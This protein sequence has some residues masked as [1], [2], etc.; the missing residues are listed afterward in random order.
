MAITKIKLSRGV[1]FAK[2]QTALNAVRKPVYCAM[3]Q[4]EYLIIS[5]KQ[6]C[7]IWKPATFYAWLVIQAYPTSVFPAI[8]VFSLRIKPV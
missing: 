7:A 2:D 8:K 1:R 5:M 6:V 4:T 3:I